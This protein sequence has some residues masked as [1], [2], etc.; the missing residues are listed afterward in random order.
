MNLFHIG[1]Q[2]LTLILRS[3]W[4][5]SFGLLFVLLAFFVT[6]FSQTGKTGFEGF[7]RMTASLLNLNLLI[8]P[9]IGV[10]PRFNRFVLMGSRI[11]DYLT[12]EWI[13]SDKA[14]PIKTDQSVMLKIRNFKGEFLWNSMKKLHIY[15]NR[16]NQKAIGMKWKNNHKIMIYKDIHRK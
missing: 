16:R 7:N 9:L 3:K 12:S 13:E 6:Y 1:R 2:Q 5:L 10:C 11:R 14:A 4:L 8:I 15:D